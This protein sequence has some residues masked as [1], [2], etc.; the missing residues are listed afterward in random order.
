[1]TT[2]CYTH[3]YIPFPFY[4]TCTGLEPRPRAGKI[5]ISAFFASSFVKITFCSAHKALRTLLFRCELDRHVEVFERLSVIYAAEF[6]ENHTEDPH[7]CKYSVLLRYCLPI[8]Y[9]R[10]CC[11]F[12]ANCTEVEVN[13]EC[14]LDVWIIKN[15]VKV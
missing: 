14:N 9:I 6:L 1:M 10:N 13:I 11:N 3:S 7:L 12:S 4:P 15:L 5:V 8:I 2:T